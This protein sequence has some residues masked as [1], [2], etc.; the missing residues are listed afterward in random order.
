MA[1]ITLPPGGSAARVHEVYAA[2]R[3]AM[4]EWGL[5]HWTLALN[6]A[7]KTAGVAD[8]YSRTIT[9]SALLLSLWTYEQGLDTGLHEIAHA[10]AGW[11]HGHDAEWRRWCR[12]VGAE[13]KRCYSGAT[14]AQVPLR[15]KGTCPKGHVCYYHQKPKDRMSCVICSKRW[16]PKHEIKFVDTR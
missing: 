11:E 16:N 4:D 3:A 5:D 6:R 9:M 7:P 12:K 10:L 15:W 1:K 8:Q 2:T 14:H 13:P